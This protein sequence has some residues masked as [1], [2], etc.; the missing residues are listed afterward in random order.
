MASTHSL[1]HEIF[2]SANPARIR[3]ALTTADGLR[4]WNTSLVGGNGDLGTE[5]ILSY[6]GRP[7]FAW[8]I[9]SSNPDGILWTC[10]KGPGD[11]VGTTV[12]F[13]F[14]PADDGRTRVRITHGGWPHDKANFTKCNTIWGALM[15]HL[16][17]H[18]ES[19]VTEPAFT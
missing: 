16:R 18:V 11:S 5:W 9:D 17:K 4:G 14:V 8:R 2:I 12:Q 19:G 13:T 7:E 10:T 6:P 1:Q 15:Y 3:D